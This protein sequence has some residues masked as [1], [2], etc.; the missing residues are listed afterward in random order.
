MWTA[1]QISEMT[2]EQTEQAI[3]EL[4][5]RYGLDRTIKRYTD[6]VDQAVNVLCD[7]WQRQERLRHLAGVEAATASYYANKNN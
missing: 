4:D 6:E 2:Q 5:R 3:L 1:E 7:I